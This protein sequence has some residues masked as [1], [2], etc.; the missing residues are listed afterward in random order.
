MITNNERVRFAVEKFNNLQK[1]IC[2]DKNIL[3]DEEFSQAIT[4]G[5]S[6]VEAQ[7]HLYCLFQE[8]IR[9]IHLTINKDGKVVVDGDSDSSK[10]NV[11]SYITAKIYNVGYWRGKLSTSEYNTIADQSAMV[12]ARLNVILCSIC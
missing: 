6:E 4:L 10:E 1:T 9:D 11:I 5:L 7:R 3:S 2:E 12:V 8:V